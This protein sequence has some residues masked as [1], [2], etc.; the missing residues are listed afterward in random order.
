MLAAGEHELQPR[1][2]ED[3][4]HGGPSSEPGGIGERQARRAPP[5]TPARG[6]ASAAHGLISANTSPSSALSHRQA[7]PEQHVHRGRRQVDGGDLAAGDARS[8]RRARTARG[9]RRRWRARTPGGE[10]AGAGERG[11]RAA[12]S[13]H[14]EPRA[15][16]DSDEHRARRPGEQ[17][18]RHR[19]VGT[20]RQPVGRCGS[21]EH[22]RI[23]RRRRGSQRSDAHALQATEPK[24]R[25]LRGIHVAPTGWQHRVHNW[26]TTRH[27]GA[28][29]TAR[30]RTRRRKT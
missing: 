26:L 22:Q 25:C 30:Q 29:H 19:Q 6:R 15:T 10:R 28:T 21:R 1:E 18:R 9:P 17:P 3:P 11:A 13:D 2:A 7:D 5:A 14:S 8:R 20:P 12:G 24:C 23:R 4:G 16:N 27:D